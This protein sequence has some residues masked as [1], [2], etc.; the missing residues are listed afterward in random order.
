VLEVI[1]L[2][3]NEGYLATQGDD[4]MRPA[5]CQ[6]ALRLGRILAELVPSESEVHALVS[7]MEILAKLGRFAEAQAEVERAAALT[8]NA[9]ERALFFGASQGH[10]ICGCAGSRR[11][12]RRARPNSRHGGGCRAAGAGRLALLPAHLYTAG[13]PPRPESRQLPAAHHAAAQLR[14]GADGHLHR[15]V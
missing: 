14:D 3:F 9:R 12:R 10:L 15:R 7:L 1:Y 13:Q 5:L 6:D 2:V 4:W 8:K 11:H